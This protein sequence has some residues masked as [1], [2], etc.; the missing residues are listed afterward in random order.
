MSWRLLFICLSISSAT[1]ARQVN[2]EQILIQADDEFNAG[3]YYGISSLLK[4]CLDNGFSSE[5]QVRAYLL[6]TQAYLILDDPI[7]AEASYLKLLKADPEYVANPARDPIDVYYLSKKFTA[8]PIITPHIRGGFNTSLPR[9]IHELTV[10]GTEIDTRNVLK[11]GVQA[12]IGFD[13]NLTNNISLCAEGNYAS[14]GFKRNTEKGSEKYFSGD[15]LSITE[16]QNWFDVPLYI[17]YA[18]DSGKIRPFGYAGFAFNFL[19][20]SRGNNWEY[21]NESATAGVVEIT[22]RPEN[23]THKRKFLNR[24][25]VFGGGAKYKVGKNFFYADLRYMPGLSNLT[26]ETNIYYDDK[27]NFDPSVVKFAEV[28][29]FFRLD[30]LSI[31]VGFIRPLYN[32]R[33]KAKSP[34]DFL[35]R[36]K[37]TTS[38]EK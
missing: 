21:R 35:N 15:N 28:S 18:D 13:F 25:L 2:C 29:D 20:S 17:K 16:R 5:Q 36:N 38:P 4:P 6:L 19:F 31:S 3:R 34:F 23:L 8:T 26:K 12:G 22:D 33:K 14:K 24:S 37:Q 30:N 10:S 7:A 11:I 32:P 9:I 27:G 1:L